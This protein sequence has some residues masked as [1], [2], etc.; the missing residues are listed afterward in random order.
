[1][2]I[3]LIDAQQINGQ[4]WAAGSVLDLAPDLAQAII[5]RGKATLEEEPRRTAVAEVPE[6]PERP[7]RRRATPKKEIQE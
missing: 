4:E 2:T 6:T 7:V 3:K 5:V 1:M